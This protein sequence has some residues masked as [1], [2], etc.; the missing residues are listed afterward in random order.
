MPNRRRLPRKAATP[1]AAD[2]DFLI[3]P[4]QSPA[5][6][7]V[8]PPL[9]ATPIATTPIFPPHVTLPATH[10]FAIAPLAASPIA[11]TPIFPPNVTL[12]AKLDDA[13]APLAASPVEAKPVSAP[14]ID[15]PTPTFMPVATP[16][17]E[18]APTIAPA[19]A[20]IFPDRS[21]SSDHLSNDLMAISGAL[22][23]FAQLAS[24]AQTPTPLTIGIIGPAGV[25]KS[26]ALHRLTDDALAL[27]AAAADSAQSSP[28]ASRIVVAPLDAAALFGDPVI[29]IAS[30]AYRALQARFPAFAQEAA[31]AAI[32]PHDNARQAADRHHE[33][34]A[35]LESERKLRDDA[36]QR[37]ARLN[38]TLIYETPG[39]R[40]DNFIRKSRGAIEARLRRFGL[41]K[42][43]AVQNY[44]DFVANL[45]GGANSTWRVAAHSVWGYG[46]QIN[47]LVWAALSA[48]LAL[49]LHQLRQPFVANWLTG[50]GDFGAKT[51]QAL[52]AQSGLIERGVLVF[53]LIAAA[54]LLLNLWRAV[55]FAAILSRGL[56]LLGMDLR[57]RRR[58][59]EAASARINRRVGVLSAEADAAGVQA[60]MLARRADALQRGPDAPAPAFASE[61]PE[62]ANR[63]ARAFMTAVSALL[64]GAHPAPQPAPQRLVF[65]LDNLDALPPVMAQ[66]LVETLR[67]LC[68][69]GCIAIIACDP[70]GVTA[71]RDA[72]QVRAQCEKWFEACF[73]MRGASANGGAL[74]A[75]LLGVSA[76]TASAPALVA[77]AANLS[78][79]LSP[80]EIGLLTALAP[81]AANTPRAAKRFLTLYRLA[82]C[83][84]ASRPTTALILALAMGDDPTHFGALRRMMSEA[85]DAV[86]DPEGPQALV[87]AMQAAR[88]ANRGSLLARDI[89]DAWASV[90]RFVLAQQSLT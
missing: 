24:L 76:P 1:V 79:P 74:V 90:Q 32:D 29:A 42:G 46:S 47:L 48:V 61:A 19:E 50:L 67:S 26:F 58:E 11:T 86:S 82:R 2:H 10:D 71:G 55:R 12:P 75:K 87:A 59:L 4:S 8:Q 54:L 38:D 65:S 37:L 57:D 52:Q 16:I 22:Q 18:P 13:I 33:I 49:G 7:G 84:A 43:D 60:E 44:R 6:T 30:A 34:A 73:V 83:G 5:Q 14:A 68:G 15:A 28:Y 62:L 21:G 17:I 69:A 45:A 35:A 23:P 31:H 20:L 85:V 64:S 41:S 25:G 53:E 81:L 63:S 9:A 56:R 89:A 77:S 78:E 51:A 80:T 72:D 39:A 27:S 3:G 70:V 40:L 66:R 88:G 36:Q